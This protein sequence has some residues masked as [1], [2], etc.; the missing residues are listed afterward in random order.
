MPI[1]PGSLGRPTPGAECAIVDERGAVLPSGALGQIACRY[2]RFLASRLRLADTR[3][4]SGWG[5]RQ[6]ICPS[7]PLG[8]TAP[9]SST[10]AHS[11]PGVGRPREPGLIGIT[12]PLFPSITLHSVCPYAFVDLMCKF[13]FRPVEKLLAD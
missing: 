5:Y 6:A 10:I 2:R 1:K 11:A 4:K 9:R 12:L 3:E 7:A 13:A 8:S